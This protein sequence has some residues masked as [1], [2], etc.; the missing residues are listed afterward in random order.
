MGGNPL[1]FSMVEP[2]PIFGNIRPTDKVKVVKTEPRIVKLELPPL[3]YHADGPCTKPLTTVSDFL[4]NRKTQ[5]D[6][7]R[8]PSRFCVG[9]GFF[10]DPEN[11]DVPVRDSKDEIV[12]LDPPGQDHGNGL[13]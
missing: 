1:S 2:E 12:P 4:K 11:G 6:T 9:G 3:G 8:L 5:I 13:F 10:G 7:N